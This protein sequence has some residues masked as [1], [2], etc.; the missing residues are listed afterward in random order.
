MSIVKREKRE[1][2]EITEKHYHGMRFDIV[3][4]GEHAS[5]YDTGFMRNDHHPPIKT[6]FSIEARVPIAIEVEYLYCYILLL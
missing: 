3:S 2:S 1:T 4:L 5:S 6:M